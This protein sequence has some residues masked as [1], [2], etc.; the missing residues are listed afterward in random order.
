MAK[1]T[2]KKSAQSKV[3]K[4]KASASRPGNAG[5]AE[6]DAKTRAAVQ[7]LAGAIVTD[8]LSG[9]EPTFEVPTRAASNTTWNKSR[10]IL[11]MGKASSTRQIFNL[12]Q[13]RKFMQTLRHAQGIDRLIDQNKT[14]SLRGMF[15]TGLGD[16]HDAA[17]KKTGEKTFDDQT[18]SDAILEDLEVTLGS[19]REELHI[20]AKKRGAMV[21]NIT[22]NDSG[23]TIDCRRM[24]SGGYAIPS[25]CE[26]DRLQFG[27]CEAEFV[28]HV[29]KDTVWQRFNED[30]FWETHN[31]IL[32]EGSGQPP[33][34]V[35]RL[36]HRLN[37]ELGL[38]IY[39]LL[40]CDPWGHYIFSV[41]KQGSISLAFESE[42]LAIPDAKFL[43][44]RADD[45]E[46]CKL[47]DSVQITLNERDIA[48]AKQ[49]AA[50]PWFR[51][52]K[53]WQREIKKLLANGFK[54]EVE[55]LINIDISYVT[56]VYVPQALEERRWLA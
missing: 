13:A 30:R 38:P 49:I 31:C 23:D 7:G 20:F 10:G 5:L 8:A 25:I 17:G 41:I 22:L 3:S 46:R 9:K 29:E 26:P 27:K 15:Y 11:Q 12:G 14:T 50:Y 44:I 39:C 35:R 34:G 6:R 40:D 56:E 37:K 47:S 19:L 54:L 1:K 43:G 51:E 53:G 2:S 36:L 45:F 28:L 33:R 32:T 52:H 18:E 42:R 4:K 48:R 16:V 55:A 24:G 21:G